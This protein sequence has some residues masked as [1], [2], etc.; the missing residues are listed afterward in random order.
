MTY[1]KLLR[2]LPLLV[3]PILLQTSCEKFTGDQTIPAYISIDSIALNTNY[4]IAGTK[5]H[6]ITDAWVYVDD[7]L[8]G[9]FQMPATFPVLKS[10][11][12]QVKILPGIKKNG[13]SAT[14]TVYEFF[15]P[16]VRDIVLGELDTTQFGMGNTTYQTTTIFSWKEDFDN[17]S[18]PITLD[19]TKNSF[20]PIQRTQSGSAYTFE[21]AHSGM[22]VL[23]SI[24]DFFE[25][26]THNE[27]PIPNSPVFLEMNFNTENSLT[28]GVVL[29]A[30]LSIY[31]LPIITL[32]RTNGLWKKI[33]IDLTTALNSYADVQTYKVYL[34]T[35]KDPDLSQP[36]ILFDNFKV[37]TRN[38][39]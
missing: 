32:N 8:I 14:R 2:L 25:C 39:K 20:V 9:A 35:F 19:T 36:T 23:D 16:I 1:R 12:H 30:Y 11:N 28:I 6:N 26:E 17:E 15:Q 31:Q 34:G 5:S 4:T 21:G 7:E 13:I 29:Y 10:G 33:Y 24:N 38:S 3:I 37:V 18:F 27:Y 22:V